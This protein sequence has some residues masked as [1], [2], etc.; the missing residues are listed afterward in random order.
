MRKPFGF[1][2]SLTIGLVVLAWGSARGVVTIETVTVGNLGNAADDTTYGAVGYEYRI[3][4]YEVTSAQYTEF[5]NAVAADDTY[6]LWVYLMSD[7]AGCKIQQ[8]GSSGSYT[9]SVAAD[10][11]D[12]PVNNV[13]W[14]D[15]ARFANWIHNGQPTGAQDATTTEDGAY[16]L[17]GANDDTALMAVTRNAG[18]TWWIP[19]ENEWYK[20]AYHKNDGVTAN[21]WNYSTGSDSTPGRDVT[22]ATNPG[23]NANYYD[24]PPYPIE[25]TYYN[26]K[27]G[28]FELSDSPYGTFDQ[29][30]NVHE[31]TEG[32][33]ASWRIRRGGGFG[34]GVYSSANRVDSPPTAQQNDMGFR[35][36][37]APPFQ[38]YP[39]TIDLT[40]VDNEGN[41]PSVWGYGAVADVYRIGTYAISA[42]QYTEFLNAVAATD[43]YGLYSSAMLLANGCWIQ[44]NGGS[45][46]YWYTVPASHV[47]RP[48]G[49]VSWG[50]AARFANWLHN[51]Q[52]TGAQDLST[53]EDGSYYLNGATTDVQLSAVT[54]KAGAIWWIPTEDEWVK[55]GYHK[56]DGVTGNYWTYPTGSD[57]EPTAVSGG[58]S[59][60][61]AVYSQPLPADVDDC[62]GLSPYGTMGQGGNVYEWNEANTGTQ[63]NRRGGSFGSGSSY[64]LRHDADAFDENPT[65]QQ[66]DIGFRIATYPPSGTFIVIR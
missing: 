50:D 59:A 6:G 4:T 22:E 40:M 18:A 44:Q 3:G 5:L 43:T 56:N 51:G 62:G 24:S 23:N 55:A 33:G 10:Y 1:L 48:A 37:A 36:A 52:P 14:G 53:T 39:V 63:R 16:T 41:T 7:P 21:Y 42:A 13:S 15:A 35:V 65:L 47:D 28:E 9:Y 64:A 57:T 60:D 11:A 54:R 32:A 58:T 66:S 45:G 20:A 30:G 61:T 2:L 38:A 34:S 8:S 31:W 27:K 17:N 26:T 12:R 49:S 46:S 25:G 19:S 29:T